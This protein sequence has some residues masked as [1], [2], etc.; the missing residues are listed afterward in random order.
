MRRFITYVIA[1]LSV[2]ILI[3]SCAE[4]YGDVVS[5]HAFGISFADGSIGDSLGLRLKGNVSVGG[6]AEPL[7]I[8]SG[9]AVGKVTEAEEY[10]AAYPADAVKHFGPDYPHNVAMRLPVVQTA[11]QGSIPNGTDLAVAATSSDEMHLEFRSILTYLRFTITEDIGKI[12]CI[13]LISDSDGRLSGDFTVDCTSG[14]EVF[15]MPNSASNVVLKPSGEFFAP[16]EYYIAAFPSSF[17]DDLTLAFENEEGWFALKSYSSNGNMRE[18]IRDLGEIRLLEF[19]GEGFLSVSSMYINAPAEGR[20]YKST[21]YNNKDYSLSVLKGAD[22]IEIIRTKSVERN[23]FHISVAS[24]PGDVRIGQIVAESNDGE[25]RM[26]Y[27]VCQDCNPESKVVSEQRAALIDLYNATD[28]DN[29]KSNDNWCS[30]LP[31][32]EWYGVVTYDEGYRDG[33]EMIYSLNLK[34]NNLSGSIPSSIGALSGCYSIILDN[35]QLEGTLP[36]EIFSLRYVSLTNNSLDSMEKPENPES[37]ITNSLYLSDNIFAG[38]LPEWLCSFPMLQYLDLENNMFTGSVPASYASFFEQGRY[39][40]LN[41]NELSGRI[42][43]EILD[44]PGFA[45]MWNLILDQRGDGFDLSDVSIPAPNVLYERSYD[46]EGYLSGYKLTY[47]DD[48]YSKNKYTLLVSWADVK[49][50][51]P[52]LNF[53]YQTYHD[54]GFEILSHFTGSESLY[55]ELA[56]PWIW[57]YS[58]SYHQ[59]ISYNRSSDYEMGLVDADGNFVVNPITGTKED[60]SDLLEAEFGKL[61]D[62]PTQEPEPEPLP[63]VKAVMLQEASEGAGVDVVLM[64][65]AYSEEEIE[66]G[67]YESVM[68]ETMEYLFEVEPFKTF[69]HLFNVHMIVVPSEKSGY[70]EGNQTPLGCCYG[71]G[72][73]ITGDDDAC[74]RYAAMSVPSERMEEVLVITV[75][76]S[77]KHGGS[78]YMYSPDGG[79]A[80]NGKSVAYIPKVKMKMTFRGLIQHEAGGHG[81]AKLA[82]EYSDVAGGEITD[83]QIAMIRDKERFGWYANVDF[84]DDPDRIKW[85]HFLA[86][87]RYADDVGIYEGAL[88]CSGGVWR[89]SYGGIMK[90]NQGVFNAPSREAIWRRIHRLAY[91]NSW[92]YSYDSFAEYDA[93]NRKPQ[94][95][96]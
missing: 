86:D 82:D 29:W 7:R 91:G 25:S 40:Y 75:M 67:T 60:I 55:K 52:S 41:G 36:E 64:G 48:I 15:P 1:I 69:R 62:E 74:F 61:P 42:P 71:N 10:Y 53:W 72:T 34:N 95:W 9:N 78:C 20:T 79:D 43:D 47:A 54:K 96:E 16:G 84:T 44:V 22:W 21:F 93:I 28:G 49:Y 68:R 17:N 56:L 18:L 32:S 70:A 73:A 33:S 46:N 65:D 4:R 59:R 14:E 37:S 6:A 5:K 92:E 24:N 76:N 26:V 81:F 31:L 66:D 80:S 3:S 94:E 90:D 63:E 89:S 2:F 85:S 19:R 58:A 88:D 12:R 50:Y 30:D 8:R 45:S 27:T 51:D 39:V 87:E 35:N 11:F 13:S 77:E 23:T 57:A 83:E 38:Y